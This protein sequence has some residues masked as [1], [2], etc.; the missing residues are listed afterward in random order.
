MS[1]VIPSRFGRLALAVALLTGFAAGAQASTLDKVKDSSSVRI[2]YANETPFAYTALDGSVTGESP[3]IVKKI[4]ERMGVEKINPV[5]TEWG[6]LIPGLRA[7]RFDLI[8]A[9]M[10][11]TPERCKQ[12][13]FTDPHYQLPDTLL[14]KAG[15]PKNLHSYEDIAKSGAKVAIMSGTVNLGY[16]RNS[17][18]SDDQILQVPDT[19]A[20][21]QAVRAGRADAAVGTQLTM[22]GLADKGGDSVEAI[23]EFKDDPAHTGYGALAFRPEDKE[24]RD[25][26]NAELKKW[27]GSEEHL[28]TVKPFG[29]DQSNITDKTAAELCGQ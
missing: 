6:S 11:I 5:L 9:G 3:E 18:I 4:F 17:G 27:L 21:L 10:Y 1:S 8:A 15:N 14:T 24:L 19:T 28:A 16:A 25:A 7:S 22:K 2:G 13:L 12:V 23:A 29:F 20:Q 26:V